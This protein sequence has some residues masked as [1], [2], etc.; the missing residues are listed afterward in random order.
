MLPQKR[1]QILEITE[2]LFN[3]FG[4]RKTGVD[5]IAKH[6]NVAKGTIYNYFGDKEGLFNE[7]I[8][9]K[10]RGF[11]EFLENTFS[12]ITDPVTRIKVTLIGYLKV[13]INN[14]FL[15]DTML[16]HKNEDKIRLFRRE[17]ENRSSKM[18]EKILNN[19]YLKDLPQE[20]KSS[21]NNTLLFLLR[22]MDDAIRNQFDQVSLRRFE[23][24]IDFLINAILPPRSIES[25]N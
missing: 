18:I 20:Q 23:K 1:K 25:N 16:H 9:C 3:R 13:S 21:I 4:I 15:S 12:R 10:L 2:K 17:L 11:D 19:S 22:G 7:L 14:P 8:K 24:E 6:A 5:D